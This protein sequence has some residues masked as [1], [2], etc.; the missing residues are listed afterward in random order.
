MYANNYFWLQP[1]LHLDSGVL[2]F[3]TDSKTTTE[4]L[5]GVTAGNLQDSAVG[6]PVLFL[7]WPVPL[8][9]WLLNTFFF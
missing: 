5:V 4:E 9:Y 1:V 7:D 8:S 6:F 2:L 3:L